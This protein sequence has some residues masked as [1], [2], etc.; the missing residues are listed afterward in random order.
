MYVILLA[1]MIFISATL[2]GLFA[3]PFPPGSKEEEERI[4]Y[5]CCNTGDGQACK[6]DLSVPKEKFQ[7][8]DYGLLKSKVYLQNLNPSEHYDPAGGREGNFRIQG[9]RVFVNV[10]P[11]KRNE[12]RNHEP[13][14]SLPDPGADWI[15]GKK[16]NQD[17]SN[18]DFGCYRIPD[19]MLIY[20]CRGDN[21]RGVCDNAPS[22]QKALFDVWIR[23]KDVP[24]GNIHGKF[25][26]LTECFKPEN[27]EE[28]GEE[29]IVF[30]PSPGGQQNLQL[31]TFGFTQPMKPATWLSPYC[32]PAIYLYPEKKTEIN[33]S[34]YPQGTMLLTIPPYPKTG[35]DVVAE[36]N[37]DIYHQNK[38]F[39]YL[40]Y[41]ASIPDQLIQKPDKGYIIAYE[42]REAFLKDL[43]T[44]LGLNEKETRQFV[45]YWVPILPK[46][47]YYFVGI[48]PVSNLHE[49]SPLLITPKPKNLIRVTLYF[50]ALDA[51]EYVA[52][53]LILPVQRD[54]FTAVEWGGIVKQD[55][56]HPFSCFM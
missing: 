39:D 52:P 29:K 54:G 20:V 51:K 55:K 6:P 22:S 16:V 35:W 21:E 37:G 50:Q 32:K 9:Q 26:F 49:I 27:D 47:S 42:E 5:Q 41:E 18:R 14:C 36:P 17:D 12:G 40:Y 33:V 1:A 11:G 3:P 48:I 46:S 45:Q 44:K 10:V 56:N 30:R 8:N 43:V 23:L 7:G 53:P 13:E 25:P 4:Q 15:Y 28:R 38:R 19:D 34:V 31:R 24:G 2:A